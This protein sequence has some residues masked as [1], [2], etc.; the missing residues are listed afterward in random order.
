V[1]PITGVV[2]DSSSWTTASPYADRTGERDCGA[3]MTF[4]L[5]HKLAMKIKAGKPSPPPPAED[6]S[7]DWSGHLF[8]AGRV[9]FILLSNTTSL[10]SAV[11]YGRGV[12]DVD[13]FLKGALFAL[14]ETLEDD[15]L[16]Y[17]YERRILPST[18]PI[19]FSGA[20]DRAVTG[21][22]NELVVQA[23]FLLSGGELSPSDLGPRLNDV[24]LSAIA[25]YGKGGYATPRA[26]FRAMASRI[27]G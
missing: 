10:Y 23:R 13:G 24:L 11:I 16:G 7:T 20:I 3:V 14:R 22:M 4:R 15:G 5:T 6:P 8:V 26:A 9:H 27:A 12:T 17:V 25:V 18:G 1:I 21:S 19:G 2:T